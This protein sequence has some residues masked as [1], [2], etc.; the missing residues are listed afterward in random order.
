MKVDERQILCCAAQNGRGKIIIRYLWVITYNFTEFLLSH[1][2]IGTVYCKNLVENAGDSN[3]Q[4]SL[5]YLPWP[6]WVMRHKIEPIY[7][8]VNTQGDQGKYVRHFHGTKLPIL[9]TYF[10]NVFET[11]AEMPVTVIV[12]TLALWA[13]QQNSGAKAKAVAIA[14][15]FRQCQYILRFKFAWK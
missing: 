14:C 2:F 6:L 9:P 12:L 13:L 8:C 10:V 4:Q 7:L 15:V 3:I 1:N 5:L 11:L